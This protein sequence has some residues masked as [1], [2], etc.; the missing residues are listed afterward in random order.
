MYASLR[1]PYIILQNPES[2][3][4]YPTLISGLLEALMRTE[5]MTAVAANLPGL[6]AYAHGVPRG[7]Q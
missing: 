2:S 3:S 1:K 4:S 7:G 5:H 6:H